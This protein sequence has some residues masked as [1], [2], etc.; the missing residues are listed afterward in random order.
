MKTVILAVVAV[1]LLGAGVVVGKMWWPDKKEDPINVILTQ[2]RTRSVVNH[3]RWVSVWYRACP[4]VLGRNPTMLV[5]WTAKLN[6]DLPLNGLKI[7]TEK[8]ANGTT[9]LKVEAQPIE[10]REPT[11][12]TDWIDALSTRSIF[13]YDESALVDAEKTRASA[14]ARYVSQF[15]LQKDSTGA[16]EADMREELQTLLRDLAGVLGLGTVDVDVKIALPA[17]PAQMKFPDVP[18]CAGAVPAVNGLPLAVPGL[19]RHE[20]TGNTVAFHKFVAPV[21]AQPGARQE[22]SL[23]A[24]EPGAGQVYGSVLL[25]YED[26]KHQG[27]P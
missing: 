2:M 12:P 19:P 13:T 24:I 20:G 16:I 26:R 4:E 14:I 25:Q 3:E 8:Q 23:P 6:Y 27:A 15:Y 11:V 10:A 5:T 22:I 7:S 21:E 17:T 9:R 18:L 1:V